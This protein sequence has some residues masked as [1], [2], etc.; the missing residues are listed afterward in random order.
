MRAMCGIRYNDGKSAMG[1]MLMLG[2]EE[3]MYLLAMANSVHW[4]HY[5]L[6]R[7]DDHVF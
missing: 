7:E 1:F 4:F 5:V 6:T 2:L 3:S